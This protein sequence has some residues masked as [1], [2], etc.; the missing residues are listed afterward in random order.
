MVPEIRPLRPLLTGK[1][2]LTPYPLL[3][4]W[5]RQRAYC[6][7][8]SAGGILRSNTPLNATPSIYSIGD[9]REDVNLK[10]KNLRKICQCKKQTL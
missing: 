5:A 1:I 3:G 6:R 9:L 8:A 4:R 2:P 7:C 10:F